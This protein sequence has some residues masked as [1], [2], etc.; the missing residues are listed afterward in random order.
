MSKVAIVG[1]PSGTGTFTISAPNGNTDRT[2]VLPDEAG[3]VL[4]SA[5][6]LASLLTSGSVPLSVLSNSFAPNGYMDIGNM[7]INWLTLTTSATANTGAAPGPSYTV[8]AVVSY[9]A[10]FKSGTQPLVMATLVTEYHDVSH[11]GVS[12][13]NYNNTQVQYL[14]SC[15]RAAGL[16]SRQVHIVAIGEKP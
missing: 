10:A 9:V 3:T 4:T 13:N 5:S 16:Q 15:Y 11:P 6:N 12:S 2:L 1:D 8:N 7:R 14:F